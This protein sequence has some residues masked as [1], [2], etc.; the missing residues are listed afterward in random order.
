MKLILLLVSRSERYI[1]GA[2]KFYVSRTIFGLFLRIK[3][4]RKNLFQVLSGI[5]E[6][7]SFLRNIGEE[8]LAY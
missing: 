4:R 8:I 2:F 1:D 3:S 5:Y 6:T 7:Y